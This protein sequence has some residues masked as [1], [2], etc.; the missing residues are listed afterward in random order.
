M[1]PFRRVQ[2]VAPEIF[3]NLIKINMPMTKYIHHFACE[4]SLP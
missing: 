4:G 2:F 3:D 1:A